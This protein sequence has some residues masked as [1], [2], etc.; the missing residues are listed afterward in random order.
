MKNK[1]TLIIAGIVFVAQ[2]VIVVIAIYGIVNI[3]LGEPLQEKHEELYAAIENGQ[4]DPNKTDLIVLLKQ[5]HSQND[6]LEEIVESVMSGWRDMVEVLIV[7]IIF[8]GILIFQLIKKH[9]N[10]IQSTR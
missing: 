6:L 9:N 3:D 2:I 8:Q 5:S 7:L 10:K 1:Y 4:I